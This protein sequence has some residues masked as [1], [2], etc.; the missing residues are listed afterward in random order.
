ME[1]F[2][3]ILKENLLSLFMN[4]KFYWTNERNITFSVAQCP[5]SNQLCF[6]TEILNTHQPRLRYCPV[7][8][9]IHRSFLFLWYYSIWYRFCRFCT[10]E[11]TYYHRFVLYS[12]EITMQT[13][14]GVISLFLHENILVSSLFSTSDFARSL[15]TDDFSKDFVWKGNE[16]TLF[17]GSCYQIYIKLKTK[18]R[19]GRNL[20]NI[21]SEMSDFYR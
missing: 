18:G 11:L 5:S 8:T 3:G 19:N 9:P 17:F 12:L 21:L 7:D 20:T 14:T 1:Y 15:I 16:K 13:D 6:V 2:H 4:S 10:L